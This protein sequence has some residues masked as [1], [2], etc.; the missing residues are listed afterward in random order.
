[1]P[2]LSQEF[3]HHLHELMMETSD[4]LRDELNGYKNNLVWQAQKRNNSA[5]IPTAYSDSAV[6]AFRTRVEATIKSYLDALEKCGIVVDAIVESE[7]LREISPLT[8]GPK[9]LSLP[10]GVTG[11]TVGAVQAEHAR[12]MERTGN[13]LYRE[14]KNRSEDGA[15]WQCPLPGG[16]E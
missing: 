2:S 1:M 9:S 10:P 4:R 16:Q 3:R 12:K 14:A 11:P 8:S 13:A 6:Y 15:H 7:M 5:G